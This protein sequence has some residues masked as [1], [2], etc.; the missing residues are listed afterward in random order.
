MVIKYAFSLSLI[1]YLSDI[2]NYFVL[3]ALVTNE[4]QLVVLKALVTNERQ[5]CTSI[6]PTIESMLNQKRKEIIDLYS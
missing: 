1:L 6:E 4:H 5:L 3:K 2:F